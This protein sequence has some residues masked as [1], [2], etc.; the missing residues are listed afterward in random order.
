MLPLRFLSSEIVPHHQ[1]SE[2]VTWQYIWFIM[3]L[4]GKKKEKEK[5]E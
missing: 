3:Y 1:A 5:K 4:Q 2:I